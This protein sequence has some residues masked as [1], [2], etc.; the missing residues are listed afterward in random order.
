M[1]ISTGGYCLGA[2]A[3]VVIPYIMAEG[4]TTYK[5]LNWQIIQFLLGRF[6]A[7]ILFAVIIGLVSHKIKE[8]LTVRIAGISIIVTALILLIYAFIR[9][10]PQLKFCERFTNKPIFRQMPFIFGFI[11]GMNICIPFL[12]AVTRV[13]LLSNIFLA[14]I[15]FMSFFAGTSL[16]IFPLILLKPVLKHERV[17]SIG[18]LATVI[19]AVYFL[20]I[21]IISL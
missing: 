10:F 8:I 6:V 1:G 12:V 14:V 20:I 2:C 16:F 17:Q 21:G 18:R 7:Y 11:I 19:A 13:I 4:E 3:P 9:N 5:R 15:F